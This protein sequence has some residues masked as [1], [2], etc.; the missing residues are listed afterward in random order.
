MWHDRVTATKAVTH[1]P[2][3]DRR[4]LIDA[5]PTA[6]GRVRGSSQRRVE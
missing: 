2:S 6:S 4:A 1:V 5:T 3:A